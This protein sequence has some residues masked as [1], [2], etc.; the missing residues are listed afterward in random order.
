MTQSEIHNSATEGAEIVVEPVLEKKE[1]EVCGNQEQETTS[2]EEQ[3]Q[4]AAALA[5]ERQKI[6]QLE[7]QFAEQLA[8]RQAVLE[9]LKAKAAQAGESSI[10]SLLLRPMAIN[11]IG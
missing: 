7:K 1:A 11:P 5:A 4:L 9:D 2:S 8:E 6:A 10:I 3:E